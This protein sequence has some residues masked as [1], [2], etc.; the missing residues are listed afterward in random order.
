MLIEQTILANIAKDQGIKNPYTIKP[1]NE[2]SE[3]PAQEPVEEVAKKKSASERAKAKKQRALRK[4]KPK[5]PKKARAMKKAWAANRAGMMKGVKTRKRLYGENEANVS[6]NV[7]KGIFEE[8]KQEGKI[9]DSSYDLFK[10]S[11]GNFVASTVLDQEEADSVEVY[12]SVL[13][14]IAPAMAVVESVHEKGNLDLE[15]EEGTHLDSLITDYALALE[16]AE[17]PAEEPPA[18]EPE[19]DE[20]TKTSFI[21][22]LDSFEIEYDK[23]ASV[24]DIKSTVSDYDFKEGELT[25]EEIELLTKVGLKDLVKSE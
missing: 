13:F 11:V 20:A 17:P 10:V 22:F 18:E 19:I 12:E 21:N 14:Y 3:N 8:I 25:A 1:K 23:E 16:N 2:A 6:F 24:E 7:V 15:S 5:D 4:N 9:S